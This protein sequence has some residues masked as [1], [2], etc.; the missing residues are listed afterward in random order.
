MH[1]KAKIYENHLNHVMCVFIGKLSLR[2]H[3]DEYP[4]DM[5][6]VISH[7][8][9]IILFSPNRKPAAKVLTLPMLRLLLIEEQVSAKIVDIRLR[10]GQ[11]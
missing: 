3:S 6:S 10:Y 4:I 11:N 7:I 1:I 5:V 2:T 8:L 9:V